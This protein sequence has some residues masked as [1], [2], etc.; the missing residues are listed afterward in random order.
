MAI[1]KTLVQAKEQ[2]N[3][4]GFEHASPAK[5]GGE[6]ATGDEDETLALPFGAHPGDELDGP[7]NRAMQKMTRHVVV[8]FVMIALVNHLDRSK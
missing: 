2:G 3:G 1:D 5:A 7:A 6:A 8:I 4:K